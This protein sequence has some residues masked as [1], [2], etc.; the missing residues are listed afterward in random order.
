MTKSRKSSGILSNLIKNIDKVELEKTSNKMLIAA[1]I[2]DALKREGLSQKE[3][4]AKIGKT[5]TDISAWLSGDRNFTI[6]TLIK[7]SYLL[8]ISLIIPRRAVHPSEIIKDEIEARDMSKKEFAD[9]IGMRPSNL[10]RL[11]RGDTDITIALAEKL[12]KALD[13][14]ASFWL[15]MQSTYNSDCQIIA[16]RDMQEQKAN[17]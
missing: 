14:P 17:R 15:R 8:N 1:K 5:E 7:I 6:D 9:R 3:F 16:E 11:L 12:E 10:S 13:I 2:G 4:A